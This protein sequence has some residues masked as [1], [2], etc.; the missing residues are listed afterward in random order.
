MILQVSEPAKK[1]EDMKSWILR[2]SQMSSDEDDDEE[3]SDKT[4]DVT[5]QDP[6]CCGPCLMPLNSIDFEKKYSL[7]IGA[8]KNII[9]TFRLSILTVKFFKL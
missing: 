2:Y 3:T 9:M 4:A 5:S 6:V 8:F 1:A 7:L